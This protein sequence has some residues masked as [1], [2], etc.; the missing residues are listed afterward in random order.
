MNQKVTIEIIC[1]LLILLFV[2][3]ALSK[4][5][6]YNTF[7]I[8]L[9]NSPFLKLIAGIIEWVI[10]TAELIIAALLTVKHTRKIGLVASLMLLLMFTVYIG[11]MLLSDSHL[12]CTCGGVIEQLTWKQHILFNLFFILLSATAIVL[13]RKQKSESHGHSVASK[14]L[15]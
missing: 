2:Y 3:A 12:P 8:Q 15:Q 10:P 11:G 6:E 14:I 1:F 7:K 13:E 9:R 4:L 5:L